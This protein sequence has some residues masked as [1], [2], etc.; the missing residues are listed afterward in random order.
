MTHT[1]AL[2]SRLLFTGLCPVSIAL[3]AAACGGGGGGGTG[4][5]A[6]VPTGSGQRTIQMV[7]TWEIRQAAVID[8]NDPAAAAPLN[9]TQVV[10]GVQGV[11]SIAGLSVARGDLET[12]LGFP[13]DA[14]LNQQDGRTVLYGIASDR[15]AQGGILQ[16]IGVAAGSVDDDTIAVEQ[17]ASTQTVSQQSPVFVRSRYSL[18]RIDVAAPP[19]LPA[20]QEADS[21]P[22]GELR[23][24][25]KALFGR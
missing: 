18:V 2:H 6:K 25:L 22:V 3:L 24:S 4:I 12:V 10:I 9:G 8:T 21:A 13:L 7:G 1:L 17:F 15:R 20:R 14:Y 19:A 5:E 11:V 23:S 16:E